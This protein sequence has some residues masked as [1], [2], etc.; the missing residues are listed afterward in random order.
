M[1]DSRK[2]LHPDA[3]KRISRLDLRAKH[4]VEGFLSGMHR[5]RYFG[6]S[7]EFL[8]HREYVPGDDL[9]H[10]DWQVWARQDRLYVKQFEEDTNMRVTLIVDISESMSYGNGPFNKFDYAATIAASLGYLALKHQD[11]VGCITFDRK[12]RDRIQSRT[13][14]DQLQKIT[15]SLAAQ[16]LIDKTAI[17]P[18]IREIAQTLPRNGMVIV[19][20]DL[21]SEPVETIRGL[22]TLRQKGHEVLLFQVIDDDELEFPF[23]GATRFEGMESDIR[24][25]CNPQAL[26]DGYLHEFHSFLNEMRKGSAKNN[27]DYQLVKTSDPLDAALAKFLTRR[28]SRN[29]KR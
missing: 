14:I 28:M 13:R 29:R 18:I 22:K 3:L 2:F 11:A 1:Q 8:Q 7:V 21:F 16:S 20:S 4:V 9:R 10:V 23:T 26:R 19:I 25:T 27:L 17:D 24:L 5:S 6:Q 12:V 15:Q